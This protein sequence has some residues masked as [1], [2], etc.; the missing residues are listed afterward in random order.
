MY[1]VWVKD[2]YQYCKPYNNNKIL[3]VT[4]IE[5]IIN[6]HKCEP[7]GLVASWNDGGFTDVAV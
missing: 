4:H 2:T 6:D 7:F 5:I 3:L 1:M